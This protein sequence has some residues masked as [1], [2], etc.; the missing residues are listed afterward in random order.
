MACNGDCGGTCVDCG[1][2]GDCNQ[3]FPS[4][5]CNNPCNTCPPSTPEC[6]TLPSVLENFISQFFG[7]V[8]K[9]TLN[10]KVVWSLPCNLDIGLPENP[11]V[12]GEGLACYF[13]RLFDTGIKGL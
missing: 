11:R 6:E 8:I 5:S 12:D 9:S 4:Q 10:G 3:T 13:L 2:C 1:G 7:R